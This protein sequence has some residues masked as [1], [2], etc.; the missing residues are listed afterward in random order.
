MFE[1]TV[2]K[3]G[4]S[5]IAE[6]VLLFPIHNA[7]KAN[8]THI[9]SGPYVPD[10][11][12]VGFELNLQDAPLF[13]LFNLTKSHTLQIEDFQK[14]LQLPNY[15]LR[16]KY[17][18]LFLKLKTKS[19]LITTGT[20]DKAK[21]ALNLQF[22]TNTAIWSN[23]IEK[24]LQTIADQ[25]ALAM[26]Q[27]VIKNTKE[28]LQKRL[29]KFQEKALEEK[30]SLLKQF[31]SDVHDLPCSI[32]PNLKEALRKKDFAECE[33]LVNELHNNLRQLINEYIVPDMNLLT[34]T[35]NIY[36]FINN[37]KRSFGGKVTTSLTEEELNFSQR[38]ANELFKVVKEWFCNIERHSQASEVHFELKKIN[39]VYYLITISDNGTGFDTDDEKN[40]GYG[41]LNIRRRLIDINAKCEIKSSLNKGSTIK[42]QGCFE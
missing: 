20:S 36:H 39:E 26:E 31:A 3:I 15:L 38:Q 30:E 9:W 28:N 14:Y 21:I 7:T 41:I 25:L 5:G 34:F 29:I 16:N 17:K 10:S 32:I 6:R 35:T 24:A 1:N 18:A 40:W 23:E 2:R 37:F 19:L 12:P 4:E 42:I 22:V 11:N 33:K 27:H 8:L 13:K